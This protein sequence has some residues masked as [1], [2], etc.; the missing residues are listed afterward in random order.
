MFGNIIFYVLRLCS[1]KLNGDSGGLCSVL[2]IDVSDF[3]RVKM[4]ADYI[5]PCNSMWLFKIVCHDFLTGTF[6]L[7]GR[8]M[9]EEFDNCILFFFHVLTFSQN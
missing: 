7:I 6:P 2:N 8:F 1:I 3:R 5:L 4:E 9:S